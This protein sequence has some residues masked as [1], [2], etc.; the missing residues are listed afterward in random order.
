[1]PSS[2]QSPQR[3]KEV[4]VRND[5][6][7]YFPGQ[8]F[9]T[10][11]LPLPM[12]YKDVKGPFLE[13]LNSD[14]KFYQLLRDRYIY[15]DQMMDF[16]KKHKF[17]EHTVLGIHLRAGNGEQK[18]F[19]SSGRGISNEMEFVSNFTRLV[20]HF[21]ETVQVSHPDR[22]QKKKPLIFLATD[23]VSLVPSIIN[24]TRAFGVSTI[25]LPQIRVDDNKG[26]TYKALKGGAGTDCL[27]GWKAMFSDM[28]LLSHSDILIAPKSS[29]FTQS[30]PVPLVFD[31][32][33]NEAGPHFCEGSNTASS[34]TCFEDLATWLF[35]DD[36]SKMVTYSWDG[37]K[38][39]II[40]KTK[41]QLPDINPPKEFA[42]AVHFLNDEEQ[43]QQRSM[44]T[45]TYGQ[46]INKKY[47]DRK[48]NMLLS[49]NFIGSNN[50]STSSSL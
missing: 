12:I 28:F 34:M 29:A 9:K 30:L 21:I 8:T 43:G 44:I 26:V 32:T 22:F 10:Y 24:A 48:E 50:N 31:Q 47:R 38:D 5:V 33:R 23:T 20:H 2:N 27:E 41:V 19:K 6:Y 37:S 16:M 13:K 35:R 46:K 39:Q 49:W 4:L 1:V 40:H 42:R 36:D 45:H 14:I 17:E 15:K 7:G 18:H 25:L 11:Q 3:G